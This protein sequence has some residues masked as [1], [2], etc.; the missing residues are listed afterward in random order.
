MRT[1]FRILT[2]YPVLGTAQDKDELLAAHFTSAHSPLSHRESATCNH[3]RAV[4]GLPSIGS[5]IAE[6]GTQFEF[7]EK[8]LKHI[9]CPG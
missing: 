5:L 3:G 4:N 9:E 2:V 8:Y 1:S 7:L 6:Y